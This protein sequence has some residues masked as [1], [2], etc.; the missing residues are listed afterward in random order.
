[1]ERR[2]I[3]AAMRVLI[4][5]G[6]RFTGLHAVRQLAEQGHEVVVF[7]R[8]ENEPHLPEGVRHIHG[9]VADVHARA[10]ELRA[11]APDV[12]IDMLAF[13]RE[14]AQRVKLFRGIAARA[15]TISSGDVYRA[16]GRIWGTEPGPP[17]PTPLTEESPLR[18]KLSVD[19]L[20]YDKTGVE[21]EVG[22]LADLPVTILRYPAV[23]GPNDPLHRLFKYVKR[24]D[25]GRPAILIDEAIFDWRWGRGYAENVGHATALAAVDDRAAGRIYNV[26][27]P[28]S[29]TESEWVRALARAHGWGGDVIAVP[30]SEL[31]ESLRVEGDASQDYAVDSSRIRRELG[32][33]E[34]VPE[35][36]ALRRTIEWE[37]ANP[38]EDID[39][40]AFDY[41]AEDRTLGSIAG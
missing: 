26:A 10:E 18:E 40:A 17:D 9:D 35:D 12:I 16:F 36:V 6:T 32:F 31:P 25:D 5:G 4:F 21:E 13:R 15:L 24:M 1:M 23:H 11:L 8:G 30:A 39:A 20:A 33:S 37:R 28:V 34:P 3:V 38:P 29:Y 7:H 41:D 27:D 2:A 14:D 22:G 19:G